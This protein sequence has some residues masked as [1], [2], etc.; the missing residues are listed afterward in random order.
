M[1]KAYCHF[2]YLAERS[3]KTE[4]FKGFVLGKS[5]FW[6]ITHSFVFEG[7]K[8]KSEGPDCNVGPNFGVVNFAFQWSI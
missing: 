3:E 7:R 1:P 4:W 2:G 6:D 5:E 8:G